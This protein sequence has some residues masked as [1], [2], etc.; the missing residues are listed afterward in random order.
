MMLNDAMKV[1]AIT[2]GIGSGKS[3]VSRLLRIAGYPVYDCDSRAKR[4]MAESAEIK[5][6]LCDA[7]GDAV[8][9]DGVIQKS[10]L[11]NVVF[12][13]AEK[14][15]KLNSIVH[16]V[17]FDDIRQWTESQTT[18]CVFVE[19]A[20][21]RESGVDALVD[22]VWI[23]DAPVDVRIKRVIA[24]NGLSEGEVRQ[25]IESQAS[26]L[27]FVCPTKTICNYGDHPI[28]VQVMKLLNNN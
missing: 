6:R 16:P 13:N 20:I 3:V 17:V 18:D 14:L 19:T 21:L 7:F 10:V 24:R 27:Q 22:E 9:A 23:V 26:E 15:N 5:N 12:G 4:L 1:V 25:R 2:G 8:V 11:A 28:M